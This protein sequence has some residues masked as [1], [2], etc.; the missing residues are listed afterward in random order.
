MIVKLAGETVFAKCCLDQ[1]NTLKDT[2]EWTC[3]S[4][5]LGTGSGDRNGGGDGIGR[6]LK[7]AEVR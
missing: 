7:Y 5:R 6:S 3:H 1:K 2:Q 4:C